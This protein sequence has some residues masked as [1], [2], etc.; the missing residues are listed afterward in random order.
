MNK[1]RNQMFKI[2][3]ITF[4][5]FFIADLVCAKQVVSAMCKNNIVDAI[6][7]EAEGESYKGKLAVAC[8]IKNRKTLRGVYGV[9]APRVVNRKYSSFV[10]V[11]AVKAYEESNVK[12]A[13]DFID[14]ASFWEGTK[15]KTP[16]WAKNMVVTATIGNQRFFRSK[17]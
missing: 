1:E 8:A 4:Q 15:F 6:I 7:G 9:K 17:E 10:F 2:I 11:Q 5:L 12:G 14:G 13:C 3:I 16:Y